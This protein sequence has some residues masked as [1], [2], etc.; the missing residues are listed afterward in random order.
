MNGSGCANPT[1]MPVTFRMMNGKVQT[2]SAVA[3][4]NTIR[5]TVASLR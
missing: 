5:R 4:Q 1:L 2:Y 3:T